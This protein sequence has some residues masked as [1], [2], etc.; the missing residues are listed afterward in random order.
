M[1]VTSHLYI[2]RHA[3]SLNNARP[4]SQRVEDPGLTDL[5]KQQ[6]LHLAQGFPSLEIDRLISSPFR[7]TLETTEAIV[8]TTRLKPEIW[9]DLHGRPG[10]SRDEIRQAF[11]DFEIPPEIDGNGWW[12]SRPYE[13]VDLARERAARVIRRTLAELTKSACRVAYVMHADFKLQF[14]ELL[15]GRCPET[16]RN[17]AISHLEVR[18]NS[19]QMLYYNAVD[20]LP[21]ELISW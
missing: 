21:D 14:L 6:A 10:M 2:I 11:P 12:K 16:P 8:R 15:D 9:V 13:S 19:I 20:H 3:Q 17:T 4:E 18:P 1:A 7:R 5:G